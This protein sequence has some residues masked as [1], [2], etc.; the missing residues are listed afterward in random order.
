MFQGFV[1]CFFLISYFD[2]YKDVKF[3]CQVNKL[4]ALRIPAVVQWVKNLTAAACI[5][6]GGMGLIAST[7]QQVKGSS[8]CGSD[9]V[10]DQELPYAVDGSIKIKIR[11]KHF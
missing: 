2:Q 3:M 8:K 11:K 7:V 5:T 1:F 4:K 10:L 9:S 6:Y